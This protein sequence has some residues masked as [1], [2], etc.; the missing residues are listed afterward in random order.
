MAA[1]RA[2]GRLL[3]R[4]GRG[5]TRLRIFTLN[6]LFVLLLLAVVVALFSDGRPSVPDGAALLINARGSVVDQ[7]S[8]VD[9]LAHFL[10]PDAPGETELGEI[11]RAIRSAA[12]DDRIRLAVL[13]LDETELGAGQAV[14]IGEALREFQSAG[15][16]VVAYGA[17]FGQS[18]YL[19]AS[20][21]DAVYM[22]P[23]G[24][25]ILP[26]YGAYQLY[27]KEL[28]DKLDIRMHIFRAGKYKEF[29][30]P[31]LRSDM[32]EEAREANRS[33][34]GELWDY[35]ASRVIANRSLPAGDFER[36]TQDLATELPRMGDLA[37]A[38]LEHHLVDELLNLDEVRARVADEVGVGE[39]G[40]FRRINL[41]SYLA[42]IGPPPGRHTNAIAVI[43]AEGPILMGR[44]SQGVIAADTVMSLIR[45][46]R[47]DDAVRAL[48]LRVNS[49]GG[50]AFAA[51]MIR[52]EL[53]LFQLTGRPLVVSMG[54]V[55]ASGGYWIAATADRILAGPT[56][57]T[58]SIGVFGLF[59][60][61]EETLAGIGVRT[62]GVGTTPLSSALNPFTALPEDMAAILQQSTEQTYTQFVNL[63]ARGRDMTPDAVDAVA[64]G[65][66]WTGARA[67]ALGLVDELGG[68]EDA[69]RAA[70]EL[71]DIS[72]YDVRR[73]R[74]SLSPRELLL[75]SLADVEGM[76][77]GSL[78][79]L[80]QSL[81]PA[82]RDARTL[83]S[84]LNDPGHGYALCEVC[85]GPG[86]SRTW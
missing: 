51:E 39:D 1:E 28:L 30:E 58:G 76:L 18:Q 65:R 72:D 19:L 54:N 77:G 9:P 48:V 2:A 8:P 60:T 44:Q 84:A 43:T 35:F 27:F 24:Q 62:D 75:G 3:R 32:S 73:F 37:T 42:A 78:L 66:V 70:A 49:P 83:L 81:Q 59:P 23:M 31:Y 82:L 26:G 69:I 22:H 21:A 68:V 12:T 45:Q 50:S 85:L 41:D 16:Q 40:D 80:P 20:Y 71:A 53:E 67:A 13:D 57:V 6:A 17:G 29:V 36:F 79:R 33:L 5:I 46:A 64:Q 15:K 38:A 14:V 52:Q 34:V 63:V 86:L 4:I 7:K 55:A 61:F 11:T 10:A 74:P 25:M 56:T 47:Q